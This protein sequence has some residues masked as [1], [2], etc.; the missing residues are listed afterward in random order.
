VRPGLAAPAQ[1]SPAA[2]SADDLI[3]QL[4]RLGRLRDGGVL[5][6][7]EFAAQKARLLA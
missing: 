3:T 5:T 6:E 4:E 1:A 7:E 2:P